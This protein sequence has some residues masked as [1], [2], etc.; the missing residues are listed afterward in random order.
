MVSD[1]GLL[2]KDGKESSL[3]PDANSP[4]VWECV[5]LQDQFKLQTQV[6]I[7]IILF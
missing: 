5:Y 3:G 6:L 1:S 4:T 7:I 2:I